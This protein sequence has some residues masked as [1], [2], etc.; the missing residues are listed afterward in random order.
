VHPARG[1]S[2]EAFVIEQLLSAVERTA[3]GC[4]PYF[5]RTAQ[6]DE[7]DLVIDHGSRQVP[8]EIKLHSA[9]RADEAR[10]L[11]RCMETLRLPRGYLVYPG[12]ERYSLG[13]GVTALPAGP[14]LARP[15]LVA[16]L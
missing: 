6:G 9:P 8:L 2:W 16:R 12:R 10:G 11:I 5:W 13:D 4:R 3:P 14:L 7:V 1:A 15:Q